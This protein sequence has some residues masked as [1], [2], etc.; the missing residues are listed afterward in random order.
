MAAGREE[1]MLGRAAQ[2]WGQ[3][4]M[5]SLGQERRKVMA[6]SALLHL[7]STTGGRENYL[8]LHAL[9]KGKGKQQELKAEGGSTSLFLRAL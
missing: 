1:E 9:R 4:G 7:T 2:N 8:G 6:H 3:V 5:C